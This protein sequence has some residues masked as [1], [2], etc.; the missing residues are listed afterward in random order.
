MS[1]AT[2]QDALGISNRRK[3][4]LTPFGVLRYAT[5]TRFSHRIARGKYYASL[6]NARV[7]CLLRQKI[8]TSNYASTATTLACCPRRL[9]PH[10]QEDMR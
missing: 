7:R 1:R 3:K 2:L 5:R 6:F 4:H 10:T 9:A 8:E